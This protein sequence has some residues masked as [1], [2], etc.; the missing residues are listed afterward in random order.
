MSLA[1]NKDSPH[2]KP[3]WDAEIKK[4]GIAAGQKPSTGIR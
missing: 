3:V 4:A 2:G 1:A